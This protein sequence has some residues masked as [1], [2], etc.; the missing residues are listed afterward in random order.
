MCTRYPTR[1][2][3]HRLP[4]FFRPRHIHTCTLDNPMHVMHAGFGIFSA[5]MQETESSGVTDNSRGWGARSIFHGNNRFQDASAICNYV[6]CNFYIG[7]LN[8]GGTRQSTFERNRTLDA[9]V[10]THFVDRDTRGTTL[11][12]LSQPCHCMDHPSSAG[13][14]FLNIINECHIQQIHT[15][16]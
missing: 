4:Q 8:I 14:Y 3:T 15:A 7:W 6:V 13:N 5:C 16:R 11:L 10:G 12:C 2:H 9:E 1:P